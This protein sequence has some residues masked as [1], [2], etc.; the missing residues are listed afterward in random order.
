[1]SEGQNALPSPNLT[2]EGRH[3]FESGMVLGSQL[4]TSDFNCGCLTQSQHALLVRYCNSFKLDLLVLP[5]IG[6]RKFEFAGQSGW[7]TSAVPT[8]RN[9]KVAMRLSPRLKRLIQCDLGVSDRVF[10]ITLGTPGGN[11]LIVEVYA[12]TRVTQ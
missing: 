9:G 8:F 12:P 1:M 3:A 2:D 10:G 7:I 5:V 11:L 6:L 4:K